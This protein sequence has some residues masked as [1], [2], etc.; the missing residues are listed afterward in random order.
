MSKN[1]NTWYSGYC[2]SCHIK[3]WK[4][5]YYSHNSFIPC[6]AKCVATY[7]A[8]Q[9]HVHIHFNG[10]SVWW[11]VYCTLEYWG[12]LPPKLFCIYL[13]LLAKDS[14][15]QKLLYFCLFLLLFPVLIFCSEMGSKMLSAMEQLKRWKVKIDQDRM[16]MYFW[17]IMQQS[18]RYITKGWISQG[19]CQIKSHCRKKHQINEEPLSLETRW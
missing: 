6:A 8:V 3:I 7:D 16:R 19:F 17:T 18:S 2:A 9:V 13:F 11:E 12:L 14:R 5:L 10:T 4:S 15:S 1:I